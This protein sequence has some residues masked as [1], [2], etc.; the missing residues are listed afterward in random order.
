[1]L[2]NKE[3]FEKLMIYSEYLEFRENSDCKKNVIGKNSSS[4]NWRDEWQNVLTIFFPFWEK[5]E[6]LWRKIGWMDWVQNGIIGKSRTVR[7][8]FCHFPEISSPIEK[9]GEFFLRV[10]SQNDKRNI[11]TFYFKVH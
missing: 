11:G 9:G 8:N 4:E 5:H 10:L 1:M 6:K 2:V 7:D 3:I